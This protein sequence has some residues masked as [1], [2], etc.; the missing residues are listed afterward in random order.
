MAG[1]DMLE[2]LARLDNVMIRACAA[3]QQHDHERDQG[4]VSTWSTY[5]AQVRMPDLRATYVD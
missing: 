2:R 1:R 3:T 5:D 4:T